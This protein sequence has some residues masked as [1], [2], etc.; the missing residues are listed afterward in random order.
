LEKLAKFSTITIR[1]VV[2]STNIIIFLRKEKQF[3]LISMP[4]PTGRPDKDWEEFATKESFEKM[5][6]A[7]DTARALGSANQESRPRSEE[8]GAGPGKR[9]EWPV[10]K[11]AERAGGLEEEKKTA[12]TNQ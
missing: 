5:K 12:S 1:T 7:R 10:A 8:T 3:V 9:R 2:Y 11:D 6:A 4:Q